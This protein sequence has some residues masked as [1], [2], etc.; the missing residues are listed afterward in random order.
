MWQYKIEDETT[1][2]HTSHN[3]KYLFAKVEIN[4]NSTQI[5]TQKHPDARGV[6]MQGM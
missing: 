3:S 5:E 6:T 1:N 4:R 2:I